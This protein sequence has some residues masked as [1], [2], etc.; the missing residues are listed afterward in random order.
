M[1]YSSSARK[2]RGLSIPE[3]N[4]TSTSIFHNLLFVAFA[5]IIMWSAIGFVIA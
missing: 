4:I 5:A 2:E 1:A 3:V